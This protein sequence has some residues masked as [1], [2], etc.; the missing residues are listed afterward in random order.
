MEEEIIRKSLENFDRALNV[1]NLCIGIM[2]FT[3]ALFSVVVVILGLLGFIQYKRWVSIRK[4]AEKRLEEAEKMSEEAKKHL[5]EV[6]RVSEE[7]KI[8]F[9]RIKK[10]EEEAK[11]KRD[12]ILKQYQ[13]IE[14]KIPKVLESTKKERENILKQYQQVEE[15]IPEDLKMKI[16]DFI[17]RIKFLKVLGIELEPEDYFICGLG[18]YYKENYELALEYFK[19]AVELKP[20]Y[21]D[22]WNVRGNALYKLERY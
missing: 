1:L 16:F 15:Q 4:Q 10:F 21:A 2:G 6:K 19:R 22:A 17:E 3:I 5:E 9:E 7:A 18:F 11:E 14:G 13:Q 8:F 20:D 12:N